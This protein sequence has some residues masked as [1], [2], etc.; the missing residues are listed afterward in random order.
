MSR[1]H[2]KISHGVLII[3]ALFLTGCLENPGAGGGDPSGNGP[4]SGQAILTVTKSG[5]GSGTVSSYPEGILCGETCEYSFAVGTEVDLAVTVESGGYFSAWGGDEDCADGKVTMEVDKTCD[6]V[7]ELN[8]TA[9]SSAPTG[10]TAVPAD[11]QVTISWDAVPEATSY[12]LYWSTASPVTQATG[13]LIS[14]V[15]SAYLHDDLTNGTTYFYVLAAVNSVGEGPE[16]AEVSATPVAG[17][18][19][20]S[21]PTGVTAASGDGQ[22]TIGWDPVAGATS[23]NIYMG[24]A[25]GVTTGGTP[26]SDTTPPF[27]QTGLTNCATYYFIVTSVNVAG[28]SGASSE[29]SSVPHPNGWSGTRQMGTTGDDD[30]WGAAVDPCGRVYTVG[31]TGGDLGAANAG[32]L[33]LVLIQHDGDGLWGWTRQDG[34]AVSDAAY[35]VAV[36]PSG[37]ITIAG[38]TAGD[39][40]GSGNAGGN[41]LFVAKYDSAG[42]QVWLNQIGTAGN[43]SAYRLTVDGNGNAYVA[44]WTDGS[45]TGYTNA[46]LDDL[47]VVKYD[48]S[49]VYQWTRQLGTA[50]IDQAWG[51]AVDGN[52]NVYV[53]GYTEGDLD[54]AG[55]GTNAGGADLFLLAYDPSGALQWTRQVGT[56][57]ADAATDIA[58]DGADRIYL[59]GSTDGDLDGGGNAGG[60]DLFLVQY[61]SSGTLQG[62]QQ[63]GSAADDFAN[64]VAL[65]ANGS[66]YVAGKTNGDLDGT[67]SGMGDAFLAKFD[68]NGNTQWTRQ[69]GTSADESANDVAADND[70]NIFITGFTGGGLDG[71]T[72]AGG[73][74]LFITK[75][76]SAGVKQ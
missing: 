13:T 43:E 16:S 19:I 59:T 33:D 71:N 28:E 20:P 45:F 54:G 7:F 53:A 69:L 35:A 62:V 2:P 25:P 50:S 11:G 38:I 46:G 22:V 66:V 32:L 74:D 3:T 26:Q 18:T 55:S 67:N 44:G 27:S 49:G 76:D 37:D 39:L 48:S 70:G 21:A 72:N 73:V 29:V 41:D 31:W 75:Y 36:D 17:A 10:V 64:G 6:A 14:G 30:G 57:G 5:T 12:N 9:P 8:G 58:V 4:L 61:D 42:N 40:A 15:T 1:M 65:D 60:L 34:T 68:S 24:A 63:A 51:A 56:S 47:F 52:G 23:Y